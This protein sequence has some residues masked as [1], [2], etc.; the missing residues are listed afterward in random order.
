LKQAE[1]ILKQKGNRTPAASTEQRLRFY[2]EV[3]RALWKYLG[4]KL[5]IDR[6]Y[7]SIDGALAQ[8]SKRSVN[9]GVSAELRTLLESCEM[10]R[11]A[12]TS[13]EGVAMQKTYDAAKKLIVELERTLR[14]R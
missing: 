2:A 10:A 8:L 9:G 1:K 11:F 5:N 3:S 14:S 4:D 6:A 12:P 13:L 7:L